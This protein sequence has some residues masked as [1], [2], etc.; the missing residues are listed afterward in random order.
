MNITITIGGRALVLLPAR[1][2]G[3]TKEMLELITPTFFEEKFKQPT[4]S[5]L[6][7]KGK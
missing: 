6:F 5:S 1:R 7:K 3:K 2:A 4:M